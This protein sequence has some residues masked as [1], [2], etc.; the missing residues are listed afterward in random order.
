MV[1][2]GVI[3]IQGDVSEHILS[4]RK[5]M[6]EFG[7]DGDI[8]SIKRLHDVKNIDAIII[9]GGE[10]TTI[11]RAMQKEGLIDWIRSRYEENRIPI[12]GTCAGCVILAREVKDGEVEGLRLMEMKVRRNA[13]GRQ[14]ESF[15]APIEVE[16]FEE[17]YHAVFIRAPLIEEV[18]GNCRAVARFEDKIVGAI[19]DKAIALSFHPELT[20]DYRFH[21]IF[22]DM[23]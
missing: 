21:R 10:S 16:G 2:L 3:S 14:R 8:I 11:S 12:M 17:P 22:F 15:E 5:A 23:I 13:F 1:R 4:A 19:Q 9:P 20:S 7:I 18:W 6:D